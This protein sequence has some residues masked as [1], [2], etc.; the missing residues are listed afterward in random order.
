[1]RSW[2]L[3]RRGES[4]RQQQR[5]GPSSRTRTED[6]MRAIAIVATLLTISCLTGSIAHAAGKAMTPQQVKMKA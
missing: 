2:P 1:L 5:R 6:I 3:R 4:A